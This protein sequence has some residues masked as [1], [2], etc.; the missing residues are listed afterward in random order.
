MGKK[1]T[2]E[3]FIERA[4]EIH[5][6]KY[7]YSKIEYNGINTN[8]CIIC[9]EHGEFWQTPSH[10]LRGCG[11]QKCSKKYHYTNDE[12]IELCKK[13]YNNT[14]LDFSK[15]KYISIMKPVC[16]ICHEKDR[17]GNEHGEFYAVPNNLLRNKKS[18]CIKC[19]DKAKL[20]T[21]EFIE[22][23]KEI[24]GNKYDYSKVEYVNAQT[25]VCIICP[26]HGEFWQTPHSHT[27]GKGCPICNESKLEKKIKDL[28]IENNIHFIEQYNQIFESN[29]SSKQRIDF[30]LPDYN[31]AIECQGRQH[32]EKIDGLGGEK[33][34]NY[35]K[36][37]D[38]KKR[39]IC[40]KNNIKIIYFI[41]EKD[42]ELIDKSLIYFYNTEELIEYIK[43]CQ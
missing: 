30:Y 42:K 7:D 23:A 31:I 32:F 35:T 37:M 28:L 13:K 41:L 26:E 36:Q 10:H 21:E 22:R 11:C 27:T 3:E 1:L 15:V 8:V 40:I 6:N 17:F 16:I 39:E 25:K 14:K 19:E 2:T 5:G 12:F 38:K 34:Y 33:K 29:K 43:C 20:T 9:P 18:G 4:K 24:H